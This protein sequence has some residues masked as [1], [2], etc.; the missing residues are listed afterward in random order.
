MLETK[1][2]ATVYAAKLRTHLAKLRKER[3]GKLKQYEA[4]VEHWRDE[5]AKWLA[6][7]GVSRIAKI[8]LSKK[9]E[10]YGG[11]L[12]FSAYDLFEGAPVPPE[13]PDDR[14]I[15][16][17]QSVLRHLGITGQE[18]VTVSTSDVTRLLGS[19]SEAGD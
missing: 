11:R 17:I 14:Q 19:E 16:D 3:P 7:T 1:I 9:A 5:I 15:R 12:M 13:Y 10:P 18:H 4:A 6:S 2:K 8:K